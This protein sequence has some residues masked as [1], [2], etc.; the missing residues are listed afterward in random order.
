MTISGGSIFLQIGVVKIPGHRENFP[1][2]LLGSM[3]NFWIS[4]Y[5]IKIFMKN[6]SSSETYMETILMML[7]IDC[8]TNGYVYMPSWE[9]WESFYMSHELS[10]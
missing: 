1:S 10:H 5:G 8:R 7:C 6:I 3:G 9:M 2:C 4:I